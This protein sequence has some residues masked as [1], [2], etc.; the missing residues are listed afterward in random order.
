M[1]VG[2]LDI[3]RTIA[4]WG[5]G[6]ATNC[7]QGVQRRYRLEDLQWPRSLGHAPSVVVASPASSAMIPVSDPRLAGRSPNT[8]FDSV[9]IAL[10]LTNDWVLAGIVVLSAL[11]LG[12]IF[13]VPRRQAQ[14]WAEAGITGKDLAELETSARGTIVQLLGGAALILTFAATWV[15]ISDTKET[16]DK[17][18]ELTSSQQESERFTQAVT[19]LESPRPEIRVGGIYSLE[20]V[21]V[22]SPRRR[23]PIVQVL[24]AYLRQR[25][26]TE[27]GDHTEPYDS[28]P[29]RN[30]VCGPIITRDGADDMQAALSVIT[31]FATAAR[32]R[33]KL[34]RLD[35]HD[36]RADPK[37]LRGLGADFRGTDLRYSYLAQV[38]LIN[39]R[40]DGAILEGTNFRWACLRGASFVG[41]SSRRGVSFVGADL[42]G[43]KLSGSRFDNIDLSGADLSGTG[44]EPNSPELKG[45]TINS[46]TRLPW[47]Q[48][49]PANCEQH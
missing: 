15:Q 42:T 25:H 4:I 28:L 21:A 19:Q 9:I 49:L 8:R 1:R 35:L 6:T 36:F 48:R 24:L 17:T 2:E 39:A 38:H 3:Q 27:D 22:E 14:R 18:L 11:A 13:L 44:L 46:C 5:C 10:A 20:S 43:A 23:S 31:R 33:F 34:T 40:F 37:D 26:E 47:R 12:A 16:T 32:P 45:A 41:A 29:P 7:S 30:P